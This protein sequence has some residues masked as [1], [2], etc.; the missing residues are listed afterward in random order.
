METLPPQLLNLRTSFLPLADLGDG[1]IVMP[2]TS[3]EIAL[4]WF[5]KE[6]F[7]IELGRSQTGLGKVLL[8]DLYL[9]ASV[10]MRMEQTGGFDATGKKTLEIP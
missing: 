5:Q 1:L 3:I 8:L 9:T 2:E 4:S 10:V 6:H 7:E